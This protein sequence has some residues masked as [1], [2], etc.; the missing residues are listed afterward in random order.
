MQPRRE[1]CEKEG[2]GREGGKRERLVHLYA[3]LVS[4][5]SLPTELKTVLFKNVSFTDSTRLSVPSE[6]LVKSYIKIKSTR[7]AAERNRE[8]KKEG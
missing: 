1:E 2:G 8:R 3:Q 6:H 5:Q 7:L 4:S